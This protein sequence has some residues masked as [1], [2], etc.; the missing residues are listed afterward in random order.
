MG[1]RVE[2]GEE[3]GE[4]GHSGCGEGCRGRVLA[5]AEGGD[6]ERWSANGWGGRGGVGGT[7]RGRVGGEPAS[8]ALPSLSRRCQPGV[9]SRVPAG[10]R[11]GGVGLR[12]SGPAPVLHPDSARIHPDPQPLA[13][14]PEDQLRN[15]PWGQTG[16]RAGP[17]C[18]RERV[19][20]SRNWEED[21]EPGPLGEGRAGSGAPG[22]EAGTRLGGDSEGG[23]RGRGLQ[24][25]EG[26]MGGRRLLG[27]LLART[28]PGVRCGGQP[29]AP[30]PQGTP[31]ALPA[32][33]TR[34]L[35]GLVPAAPTP[36]SS[37]D[38][39]VWTVKIP[40]SSP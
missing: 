35:L 32:Q 16:E 28:P 19:L 34:F 36:E 7:R 8:R 12:N 1:E 30:A 11:H 38:A 39:E 4:E 20:R 17:L 14:S 10:G 13:R 40:V 5:A 2:E 37:G 27:C 23:V 9:Q 31:L 22:G 18:L 24:R 21:F 25:G 26:S 3:A 33:V 6:G 29:S 15:Q